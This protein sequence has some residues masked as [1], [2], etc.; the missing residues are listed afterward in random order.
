VVT[1]V[2]LIVM[3]FVGRFLFRKTHPVLILGMLTGALTTTAAVGTLR[4]T[5]KSSVPL[6]GFTVPYAIGNIVL[7]IG[8]AVVVAVIAS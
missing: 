1:L 2:P 8:G 5:A 7:T 6:L 3:T 4:E